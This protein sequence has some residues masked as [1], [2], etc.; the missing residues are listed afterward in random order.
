VAAGDEVGDDPVAPGDAKTTFGGSGCGRDSPESGLE[1]TDGKERHEVAEGDAGSQQ[2]G[3]QQRGPRGETPSPV[4]DCRVW[5]TL[6]SGDTPGGRP[7]RHVRHRL[8]DDLD[9]I[10]ATN[11][12][13][14]GQQGM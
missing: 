4:T 10:E 7:G 3:G 13:K 6:C 1:F 8:A 12:H 14:I 11:G 9:R 2:P 5:E